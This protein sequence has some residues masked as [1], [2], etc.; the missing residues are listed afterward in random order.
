[1]CSRYL[2][3]YPTSNQDAKTIAKLINS[4]MIKHAYSLTTLIL[5]NC[6]SF[7]SHVTKEVAGVLAIT[8]KH[9]NREHAQ[10]IGLLERFHASIR[11]ASKIERVE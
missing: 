4:I 9:A 11:Q 7:V 1:M 5:D 3:A 6:T 8:P 10:T 2:F